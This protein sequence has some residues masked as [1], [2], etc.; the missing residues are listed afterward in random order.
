MSN[1]RNNARAVAAKLRADPLGFEV[2]EAYDQTQEQLSE[3][4]SAFGHRLKAGR[5]LR[6]R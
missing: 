6:C 5:R 2:I 4:L 3:Q 1:A